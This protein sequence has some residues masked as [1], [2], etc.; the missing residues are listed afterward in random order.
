[1]SS[2]HPACLCAR[3]GPLGGGHPRPGA[4]PPSPRGIPLSVLSSSEWF[5]SVR[6]LTAGAAGRMPARMQ[7]GWHA[8]GL[9]ATQGGITGEGPQRAVVGSRAS[10]PARMWGRTKP[11]RGPEHH[12]Q[13]GSGVTPSCGGSRASPPAAI[14][15]HTTP[16]WDPEHHPQL[17]SGA[18]PSR[19]GIQSITP[20]WDLGRHR[21][22]VGSRASPPAGIW[23]GTEP[24]WD[25][26]HHPHLGSGVT[27]I[28]GRS[29]ASPPAGIWGHTNPWWDPDHHPQL[30]R[31]RE[32]EHP[33]GAGSQLLRG[34][35]R[36]P[37]GC[38]SPFQES[39]S[40]PAL[41][42][43]RVPRL[44][45]GLFPGSH[46]ARRELRW[47]AA[48]DASRARSCPGPSAFS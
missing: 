16:W 21:A 42:R 46:V 22:V 41:L 3:G 7:A 27:P 18:A 10:P 45:F 4:P 2:W 23:G 20:S 6:E 19:G 17:G 15:G 34:R 32:D 33:P 1:M 35:C 14:W 44:R 39:L 43:P 24:W 12:P 26:E 13:L 25:P 47:A 9:A 36:I 5:G 8:A 38:S 40:P 31:L 48:R 37:Q 30:H 28:R 29:R 11:W